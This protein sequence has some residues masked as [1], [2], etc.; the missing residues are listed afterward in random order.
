MQLII[1][2]L[3]QI[4]AL[5]G[6]RGLG[7][8]DSKIVAQSTRLTFGVALTA[9]LILTS[10]A[11]PWLHLILQ[12]WLGNKGLAQGAGVYADWMI[13]ALTP[14]MV[15]YALRF[16]IEFRWVFPCNLI[17]LTVGLFTMI[18]SYAGGRY[19]G[20]GD[21]EAVALGMFL[22]FC[23]QGLLTALWVYRDLP[24]PGYFGA[25]QLPS[26]LAIL[27]GANLWAVQAPGIA[28]V[29]VAMVAS[30]CALYVY[31]EVWPSPMIGEVKAKLLRRG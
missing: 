9:G 17:T 22:M 4:V 14:I 24:P 12:I 18:A 30:I 16:I 8:D 6:I 3:T 13:F 28:R 19:L 15:F 1:G 29:A 5:H 20:M 31:F 23:V 11:T 26:V 2:P 7:R 21:R 10:A 25:W 27:G